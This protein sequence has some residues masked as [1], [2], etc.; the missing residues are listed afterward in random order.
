LTGERGCIVDLLLTFSNE[1][2]KEFDSYAKE[3]AVNTI[4]H[5]G[6]PY[7]LCKREFS[8]RN[9]QRLV[10]S[11]KYLLKLRKG[12][13][14]IRHDVIIPF[15]NFPSKVSYFLYKLIPS[16]KFTFWH[17]LGLDSINLD[18]FEY[19]AVNNIP[20][21]IGNASN[22]LDMFKNKYVVD[23][24][25]LNILTQYVSLER[26]DK[27]KKELRGKFNIS[28]DKIVIGMIAH[29]RYDKYHDVVLDVFIKLQENYPQAH[30][31]FLGNK[32]ND[33]PSN[34]K[35]I[36]LSKRIENNNWSQSVTLLSNVD[37]NDVLNLMD[38]GVLISLIEGTPNA[39]MEYMLY[40]MPVVA[41]HHPGC[42]G[43]LKDSPFLIKNEEN[44][45]YEKLA[46]LIESKDLRIAEGLKNA[47]RIKE[48]DIVSYVKK[49]ETIMNKTLNKR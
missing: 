26:V 21:V 14:P 25:K 30:L 47:E 23:E 36:N 38:I 41:S 27:N 44:L 39:V 16:V 45:I 6:S 49:I 4:F 28:D 7:L 17:Q 34:A 13:A 31:L 37:V 19:I 48:Y 18:V 8:Y 40:G 10:W 42:Q 24:K 12:L 2:T 43:L 46:L 33:E 15:L 22:C 1:T 32:D 29:F 20:C 3:C 5:F 35:F 11:I 9:L